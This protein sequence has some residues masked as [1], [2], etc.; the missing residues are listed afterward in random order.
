MGRRQHR[1]RYTPSRGTVVL[2]ARRSE[3]RRLRTKPPRRGIARHLAAGL[4]I[5]LVLTSAGYGA[6][7]LVK[8]LHRAPEYIVHTITVEGASLLTTQE[9]LEIAGLDPGRPILEYPIG[10]AHERLVADPM[11]R[12]ASI[13]RKLPNTI[14]VRV[15]ERTPIARL[16]DAWL[17]DGDGYLL[18]ENGVQDKLPVITG[19]SPK[20]PKEG[21]RVD[22]ERLDMALDI[23]KL[24]LN[25]SLPELMQI[26]SVYVRT[27][28]KARLYAAEGPNTCDNAWFDLGGEDFGIRLA[29]LDEVLR[30]Q[31]RRVK[32]VDLTHPTRVY[33]KYVKAE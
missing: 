33:V 7:W 20:N 25:S 5:L 11:I 2:R 19:V 12:S 10:K 24:Y 26:R 28:G 1:P 29:K 22:D 16:D 21:T 14:I 3:R 8:R 18:T 17:V 27:P 15:V 31:P 30:T 23:L 9:V 13:T 6:Y 32:Q 4:A